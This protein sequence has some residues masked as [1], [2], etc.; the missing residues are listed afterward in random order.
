MSARDMYTA[1]PIVPVS[2]VANMPAVGRRS[3]ILRSLRDIPA[4]HDRLD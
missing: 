4:V 1:L 3:H 2:H